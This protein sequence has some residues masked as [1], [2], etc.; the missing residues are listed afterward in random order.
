MGKGMGQ[1]TLVVGLDVLGYIKELTLLFGLLVWTV[2]KVPGQGKK[3]KKKEGWR[4]SCPLHT[5]VEKGLMTEV[6]EKREVSEFHH[7][8]SRH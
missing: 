6:E 1:G 2:G 4:W 5:S 8:A 7:C 3:K